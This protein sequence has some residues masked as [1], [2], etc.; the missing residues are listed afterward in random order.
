[1]AVLCSFVFMKVQ[2]EVFPIPKTTKPTQH[3]GGAAGEQKAQSKHCFLWLYENMPSMHP[4]A[5][6]R[7]AQHEN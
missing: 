2:I 1:M 3:L 4:T 5:Q 7:E 6:I